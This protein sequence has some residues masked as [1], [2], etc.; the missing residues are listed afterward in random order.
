MFERFLRDQG[1]KAQSAQI[2]DATHISGP[3]QRNTREENVDY[4]FIRRFAVTPANIHDSQ[5][6]PRLLIPENEY[7]G[8]WADSAYSDKRFQDLLSLGG[9]ESLIYEKGTRNHPL[10]EAAK[11]LNRIKS[12]TRACVEH[13][14]GYMTMSMGGKLSRKSAYQETRHGWG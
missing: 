14:F 10:N 13:V 2:I 5:M 3:K 6:L 9:F 11:K 7:D 12:K 1:F 4:C 8:M